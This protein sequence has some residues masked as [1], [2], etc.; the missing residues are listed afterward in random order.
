MSLVEMV[1]YARDDVGRQQ[2]PTREVRAKNA[3]GA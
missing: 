2:T 3:G 1:P